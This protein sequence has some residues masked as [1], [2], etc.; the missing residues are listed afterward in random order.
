[1]VSNLAGTEVWTPMVQRG[2]PGSEQL[3]GVLGGGAGFGRGG[4]HSQAGV[5]GQVQI[6]VA[7][8]ELTDGGVIEPFGPGVQPDV[9]GPAGT[10]TTSP[11]ASLHE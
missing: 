1:V 5:V 7:E 10:F 11:E 8:R 6:V 9:V 4:A 3:E 2:S